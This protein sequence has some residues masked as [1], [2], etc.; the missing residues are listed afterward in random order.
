M[1]NKTPPKKLGTK[2]RGADM[3]KCV[4]V[5][6][7][8]ESLRELLTIL[9]EQEEYEVKTYGTVVS[10][11]QHLEQEQPDLIIMDVMLPDGDGMQVC[12]EVK[13]NAA[14]QDIPIIM[15]SAHRDFS[16]VKHLCPAE[17]F[18]NKPFDIDYLIKNVNRYA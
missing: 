14:T 12:N 17:A 15:M 8:D 18:I 7:D 16:L 13:A 9:L 5:L 1:A 6:E 3:K 2:M 11:K 10:F 4:F